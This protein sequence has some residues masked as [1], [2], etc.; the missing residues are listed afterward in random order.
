[1][2]SRRSLAAEGSKCVA[3][4]LPQGTRNNG[5]AQIP[6]ADIPLVKFAPIPEESIEVGPELTL[7][8]N[9]VL[10]TNPSTIMARFNCSAYPHTLHLPSQA[11]ELKGMGTQK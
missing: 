4:K 7:A 10:R 9:D 8:P 11:P 6:P 2:A 5:L 1:L 3:L